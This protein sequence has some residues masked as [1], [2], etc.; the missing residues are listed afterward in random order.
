M[1]IMARFFVKLGAISLLDNPSLVC[2]I[3]KIDLYTRQ[4]SCQ[5]LEVYAHARFSFH[6]DS[7]FLLIINNINALYSFLTFG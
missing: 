5:V 7:Y 3:K 4:I 1:Q 6:Y 2:K